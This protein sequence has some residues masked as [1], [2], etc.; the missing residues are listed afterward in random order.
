M[1]RISCLVPFCR[2]TV[3][4]DEGQTPENTEGICAKH[5]RLVPRG[6]KARRRQAFRRVATLKRMWDGNL[7]GQ[8][9]IESTGRYLKYCHALARAY[10]QRYDAWDR[11]KAAA[12]EAAAQ[13]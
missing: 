2:C 4:A 12:I 13:I 5:W 6:A 10:Q 7:R 9:R 11:C 1:T 8:E 3:K